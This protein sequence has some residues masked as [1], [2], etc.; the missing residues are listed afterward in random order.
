[1]P[2]QDTHQATPPKREDVAP[3]ATAA[4]AARDQ[5]TS[6]KPQDPPVI[7]DYASL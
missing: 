7:T 4:E 6:D 5:N 2:H 1:M 3:T